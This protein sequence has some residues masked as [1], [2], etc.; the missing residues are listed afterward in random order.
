MIGCGTG[1]GHHGCG[2]QFPANR[3]VP[4]RAV[5][6]GKGKRKVNK[7]VERNAES[8]RLPTPFSEHTGKR[9][10]WARHEI[11]HSTSLWRLALDVN[12]SCIS[13]Q[14]G[15]GRQWLTTIKTANLGLVRLTPHP[16]LLS[17]PRRLRPLSLPSTQAP[18]HHILVGVWAIYHM[19]LP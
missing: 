11:K 13:G 7:I 8:E 1:K 5:P 18:P 14:Y 15:M 3:T 2:P 4:P 10:Q 16:P 6:I 19:I 12:F 17:S 9:Q